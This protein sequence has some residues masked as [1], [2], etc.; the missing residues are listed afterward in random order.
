MQCLQ[1]VLRSINT[2]DLNLLP[3]RNSAEGKALGLYA[4]REFPRGD[5]NYHMPEL[6]QTL[7]EFQGKKIVQV[8]F[9]FW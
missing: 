7:R 8:Q 2:I 5:R 9:I 1:V 3:D 6:I 4:D